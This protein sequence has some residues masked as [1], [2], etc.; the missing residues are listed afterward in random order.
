[1]ARD[2]IP[3]HVKAL[4]CQLERSYGETF[5]AKQVEFIVTELIATRIETDA[6]AY[7]SGWQTPDLIEFLKVWSETPSDEV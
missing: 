5:E 3:V 7:L 1:M 2:N 4:R 6:K